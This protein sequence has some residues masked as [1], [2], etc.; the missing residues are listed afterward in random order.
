MDAVIEFSGAEAA[1]GEGVRML[2]MGGKMVLSAVRDEK[3]VL[4]TTYTGLMTREVEIVG[5]YSST[6]SDLRAVT[7]LVRGGGGNCLSMAL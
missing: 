7:D 2:R 6:L 4:G 1:P 3:I 5:S